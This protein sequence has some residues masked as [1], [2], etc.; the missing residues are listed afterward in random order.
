MTLTILAN[1]L[2]VSRLGIIAPRRLGGATRRNR[3]KRLVREIY[4][5]NKPSPGLDI[6]VLPHPELPNV[7]FADLEVDYRDAVRRYGRRA[8]HANPLLRREGGSPKS[9]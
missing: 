8:P 5:L 4:R 9:M 2:D 3:A 7:A 6:V 1:G